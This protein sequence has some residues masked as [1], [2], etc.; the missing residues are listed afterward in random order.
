MFNQ[1]NVLSMLLYYQ[2]VSS[3]LTD[4]ILS[5]LYTLPSDSVCGTLLVISSD[6]DCEKISGTEWSSI[7]VNNGM[8][9]SYTE[10][11]V[12]SNNPCLQSIHIHSRSFQN[13]SSITISNN[14]KL[15]SIFI[16]D[17][18]FNSATSVSFTGIF[19]YH[20]NYYYRSSCSYNS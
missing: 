17:R 16:E 8:C 5:N 13:A 4:Q 14:N 19:Y 12:I 9:N 10:S 7:I 1:M 3:L 11:I 15:G 20:S 18:V 2:L 6:E